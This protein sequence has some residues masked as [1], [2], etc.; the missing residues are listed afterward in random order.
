MLKKENWIFR[1]VLKCYLKPLESGGDFLKSNLSRCAQKSNKASRQ[2]WSIPAKS[3]ET[4]KKKESVS[5]AF[6]AGT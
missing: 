4:I 3:S 5:G 6:F 1:M 2:K